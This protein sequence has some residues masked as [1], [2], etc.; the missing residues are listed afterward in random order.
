IF[1]VAQLG[2]NV[3][4]SYLFFGLHSTFF[5]LMCIIALWCLILCT[6]V[7]TFRFSVAGGAL[8]IPYFLWV[9]FATI[10]TYTVMTMNPVSYILF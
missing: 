3:A 10:L 4:W 1:F 5:G 6:M 8:M 7:Q 2:F 9:S